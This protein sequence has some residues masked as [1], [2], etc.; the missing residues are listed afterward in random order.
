MAIQYPAELPFPLRQDYGLQTTSPLQRTQ[1]DSG[2]FRSRRRFSSV[3]TTFTVSWIMND[4][5][6]QVFESWFRDTIMD[7]AAWFEVSLKTPLGLQ[8]VEARFAE[9]YSG[10][11]LVGVSS[12]RFSAQLESRE[13]QV[14][15]S[16]WFNVAPEFLKNPG[17]LD[18]ALNEE[19]P[20]A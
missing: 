3:P 4:F 1:M 6:A 2:R 19:W 13:R 10:P 11:L 8:P 20:K 16:E 7:G 5:Q 12:W 17:L 15:D 9:M 14:I 18:R